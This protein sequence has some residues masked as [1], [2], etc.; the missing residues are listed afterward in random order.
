MAVYHKSILS[1]V[2]LLIVYFILLGSWFVIVYFTLLVK[3]P[4]NCH[5]LVEG[6]KFIYHYPWCISLVLISFELIVKFVI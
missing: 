6:V 2:L 5:Y 3:F 1:K 4:D